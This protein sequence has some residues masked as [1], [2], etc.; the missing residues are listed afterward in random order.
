MIRAAAIVQ[1]RMG[2]SRMPGKVLEPLAGRPLL[3][4]VV[5]RL[6]KSRI[7]GAIAVA[8]STSPGDDP[9]AEYAQSLGV[10]VVRG[11]E[12]D[13][14]ARFALAAQALDADILVR[15]TGDAPL[16]DPG[17]VDAL[18]E[19]LAES[20]ADFATGA[21]GP[22]IHEGIDPFTRRAL[23]RLLSE[24]REDPV[25]K[26]HVTGY[27][28]AHPGFAS[29]AYLPIP[30]EH[31]LSGARI[32]VDA[33]AD[34]QF[35]EA[36]YARLGAPPGEADT[37]EVVRLLRAEP[38]LLCLNARVHQKPLAQRAAKA[39]IRCDGDADLGLGHVYRCLA[40]ADEL[41]DRQGVGV[42]FAVRR[43][44]P[45]L[46]LLSRAGYPVERAADGVAEA[47]WLEAVAARLSPDL[48]VLDVRTPLSREAVERLRSRVGLA[49]AIDDASERRLA[50]DHVF[51][52]PVPQVR[53]LDWTSFR[54]ELHCGFEW[55]L[56][57]SQFARGPRA[58]PSRD[59]PRALVAM[60]G[61]DPAGL[62]L[63][64]VDALDALEGELDV[65]L[66]VGPAFA[67]AEALAA[68][69]KAARR[70]FEV[71]RG[72]DD[73]A[74]LMAES[75]LAI[76]SFGMTAYELAAL[77]VPSVLLCLTDDHARSASALAEA[78]AAISLGV[79]ERVGFAEI[80]RRGR[81][82]ASR[83]RPPRRDVARGLG[84]HRWPGRR[85]RR[86][87][88][89]PGDRGRPHG[90][91]RK[92]AMSECPPPRTPAGS[93]AP[94]TATSPSPSP[95]T[96]SAHGHVAVAVAVAD[97]VERP[98]RRRRRR[99]RRAP[100]PTPTSP[101]PTTSSAHAH[102][103]VD[104]HAPGGFHS[105]TKRWR[106]VLDRPE[107][108]RARNV[109]RDARACFLL[110]TFREAVSPTPLREKSEWTPRAPLAS[111]WSPAEAAASAAPSPWRWRRRAWMSPSLTASARPRRR[112]SPAK[113]AASA[114][115]PSASRWRSPRARA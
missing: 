69:L 77:G 14:L 67:H 29:A 88:L 24:A 110:C 105:G 60:G 75:D 53:A 83:A 62:T 7:L 61:S 39:L 56:L 54:G 45:A 17:I 22:C 1:A 15:V 35:L 81:T 93:F 78:G 101:S 76:A 47:E 12:D 49:A 84:A 82:P 107:L 38:A 13:V 43:G 11:P 9:L 87:A 106:P 5:H 52:P 55:I 71:L 86:A 89:G 27:F 8:T 50:C 37:A 36:V 90:G 112:R 32:S 4:H 41:R 104:R 102:V 59:V 109:A 66:L 26:E 23:E 94:P 40:L 65:R 10:K 91:N 96:S 64:A 31:Q 2:S 74:G 99:P 46:E 58:L 95:T 19:K 18:V 16:V 42:A 100:T 80:R 108:L 20:G 92:R 63:K 111:P 3:W 21:P 68:R 44:A 79:H 97:H 103:N 34:L 70:R 73:V 30:P 51:S 28:K 6:R 85:A 113:F 98:R 115:A 57:R 48:L 25:A 33:P 72:V 114:A